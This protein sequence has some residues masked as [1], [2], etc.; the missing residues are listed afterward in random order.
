MDL[1]AIGNIADS[2]LI[3]DFELRYVVDKGLKNINNELIKEFIVDAKLEEDLT[4]TD[5]SFNVAN[6]INA[7]IRYGSL[8]E[9]ED[10]FKALIGEEE[11]IEYTPRKSKS[12]PN[13]QTEIQT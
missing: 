3:N 9:K 7:V 13:P 6:K 8:Q 5:I 10:L 4:P 2:M 1:V 12:Y 11:E